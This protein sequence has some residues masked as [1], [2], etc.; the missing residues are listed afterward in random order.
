MKTSA[1]AIVFVDDVPP[2]SVAAVTGMWG[3]FDWYISPADINL[4]GWDDSSGVSRIIVSP[5]RRSVERVLGAAD[6]E[7]GRPAC[8]GVLRHRSGRQRRT[9]PN[10]LVPGRYLRTYVTFGA[11]EGRVFSSG[12]VVVSFEASDPVS[13]IGLAD[14]SVDGSEFQGIIA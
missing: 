14:Y 1:D 10:R 5:G 8:A 12:D 7:R 3:D 11:A 4:T 2:S 6:R 13:G 9:G